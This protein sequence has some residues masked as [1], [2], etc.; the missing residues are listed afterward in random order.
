MAT[1]GKE[2][3]IKPLEEILREVD[4]L[5]LGIRPFPKKI[6]EKKPFEPTAFHRKIIEA[7]PFGIVRISA[8][9]GGH[10]ISYGKL[11]DRIRKGKG[12]EKTSES[13][14]KYGLFKLR[15]K[16]L[17]PLGSIGLPGSPNLRT[18]EEA[19]KIA[20]TDDA[21]EF[22]RKLLGGRMIYGRKTKVPSPRQF[23]SVEQRHNFAREFLI[24]TLMKA[25]IVE[26]KLPISYLSQSVGNSLVAFSSKDRQTNSSLDKYARSGLGSR[27]DGIA[28]LE[29]SPQINT[30]ENIGHA[31]E[32]RRMHY[33][34]QKGAISERNAKIY[35]LRKIWEKSYR[36][37]GGA[38]GI[39]RQRSTQLFIRT[40]KLLHPE[41][42]KLAKSSGK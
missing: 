26:G 21:K 2:R 11:L 36:E 14:L 19:R 7:Y 1:R 3:K 16:G 13:S 41:K 28:S 35:L 9:K 39:S 38:F 34:I 40:D 27:K 29:Q 17:I 20:D 15:R 31:K 25:R 24:R 10:W 37:I 42:Y 33:K 4:E 23:D 30:F 32:M 22:L 6:P 8:S 5:A 18:Y 12:F